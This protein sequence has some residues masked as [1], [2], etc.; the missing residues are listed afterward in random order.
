MD[1]RT[2]NLGESGVGNV[3]LVF[4]RSLA[5]LYGVQPRSWQLFWGKILGLC[6]GVMH[7][8][9]R[10]VLENLARA[11]PARLD[12]Q[13]R[14]FRAS[15]IHLGRLILEILL[16]LG[17][18]KRFVTRWMTV[19]GV[20][21]FKAARER[22]RGVIFLGSHL[23]NWEVM[24]V[25]GAVLADV[26]LMMVTKRLKPQWL[27]QAIEQGRLSCGV[28]ATYEPRTLKDV[29]LHLKKNGSVGI[30]LDQFVGPPVGVRVPVFGTPVGTS[31]LVATLAKRTGAAVLPVV[32]CRNDDGSWVL[33]IHPALGWEKSEDPHFELADNTARYSQWIE[34]RIY[35]RPEQWL[36]SHRRFKG[37]LS[38]LRQNEWTKPR[39]RS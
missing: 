8:R 17:P 10:V 24:A 7:F 14:I 13:K 9:S 29:L 12:E 38:A 21:N 16:V 31:M 5:W 34:E 33:E 28:R 6:L 19:T 27:H 32:C 20:E 23:G 37:D 25:G 11:Y 2:G 35:A 3:S 26:N 18:M 15:Y 39:V 36:W 22:G 4:L 1:P 30:V